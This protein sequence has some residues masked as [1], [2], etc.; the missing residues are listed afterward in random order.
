MGYIT[1]HF[2][3]MC[4][5]QINI[6]DICFLS[7]VTVFSKTNILAKLASST[8]IFRWVQVSWKMRLCRWPCV[9]PLAAHSLKMASGFSFETSINSK[10][11]T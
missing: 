1:I 11:A 9:F 10:L 7:V 5:L 4:T 3:R 2:P 8:D 6:V